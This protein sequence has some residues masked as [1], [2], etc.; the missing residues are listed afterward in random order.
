MEKSTLDKTVLGLTPQDTF[1]IA[2]F[3]TAGWSLMLTKLMSFENMFLLLAMVSA[4][5][6]RAPVKEFSWIDTKWLWVLAG[7]FFGLSA[8]PLLFYWPLGEPSFQF[9]QHRGT[10]FVIAT[11]VLILF[12][13]LKPSEDVVWISLMLSTLS[14]LVV[15]GYEWYLL[16]Q[17]DAIYTY[18]FGG[19]V[20]PHVIH[21]GIY[22]NLLTVVL[23]GGFV[24]A[25][26]K[27]PWMVFALIVVA[28]ISFIGSL[29]SDTRTAWAGLPEALVGWSI[30]YSLYLKKN[31]VVSFKRMVTFWLFFMISFTSILMYFGD[32]VDR[33]WDAMVGDLSNY[34]EGQGH[35]GSVGARLVLF[36]AGIEGF[37]E[38]PLTG[39]GEDHSM[40]EQLARTPEIT[41]EI[42]GREIPI[43]FGHL[44]NQYIEAAFT[45]GILGVLG[46]ILPILYL[47][48]FFGRKVKETK[49]NGRFSP[50]PL[51]GLLFVVS[52]SI[53][54]L[55][56][57]WIHLSNGVA[58]Y[59]FFITLF[60]F[61]T[62]KYA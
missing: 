20:T 39:V 22:S 48:Y 5:S 52:S 6:F 33:R 34:V 61:M 60:V 45:R 7:V 41:K 23:L 40:K 42:Y 56:E 26:Q 62:R 32:R 44:H 58:Y 4:L 43:A 15:I 12:W 31:G 35:A 37:L 13:Q 57:A 8:L 2:I 16:G 27:G 55:A 29:V 21:F 51:A 17:F 24:W 18:R 49:A 53:S 59:L 10:A 1:K 19:D 9:L 30:F 25:I 50:W 38:N 54:M 28:L 46:L 14:V 36:Q 3:T 47:V 11:F